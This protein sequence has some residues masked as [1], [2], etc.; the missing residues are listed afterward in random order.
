LKRPFIFQPG[1]K[2][3]NGRNGPRQW[4]PDEFEK[5]SSLVFRQPAHD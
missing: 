5:P 4:L 3:K 2:N 1:F